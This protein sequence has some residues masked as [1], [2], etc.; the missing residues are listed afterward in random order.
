[1]DAVQQGTFL[2]PGIGF[3]VRASSLSL[4]LSLSLWIYEVLECARARECVVD[5]RDSSCIVDWMM[6]VYMDNG[7][8]GWFCAL[9]VE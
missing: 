2:Y 1:M 3:N 9:V 7:L 8:N 4:S 6:E 5:V